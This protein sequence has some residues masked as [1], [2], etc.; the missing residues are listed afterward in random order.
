MDGWRSKWID[1]WNYCLF[2]DYLS[3]RSPGGTPNGGWKR[4]KQCEPD[5]MPYFNKKLI[6]KFKNVRSPTPVSPA[7]PNKTDSPF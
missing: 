3:L 2:Y 1:R 6:D 5:L 4:G 7:S